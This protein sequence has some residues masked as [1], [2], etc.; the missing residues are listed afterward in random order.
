MRNTSEC[1]LSPESSH[2]SESVLSR[3]QNTQSLSL[4][5][6]WAQAKCNFRRTDGLLLALLYVFLLTFICYPGLAINDTLH[7]LT[8]VSNYESWHILL[9]QAIFNLFDT[10]GRYCGGVSCLIL[11]SNALIKCLSWSRTVFLAS[12]FLV[13]FDIALFKS[14]WFILANLV[15]FSVSNGYVSTLC[16][17]KAPMAVSGPAKSQ[18]GGFVGITISTGIVLGSI[19][20]FGLLYLIEITPEY[21]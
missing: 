21:D 12:F 20:A 4:A 11:Q 8:S 1:S 10:I 3:D 5:V 2:H 6:Y 7:F 18:I 17:V 9:I 13:S 16:A 15:I 19:L 14:D